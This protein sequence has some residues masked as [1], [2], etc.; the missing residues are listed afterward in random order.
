MSVE[1]WSYID[2]GKVRSSRG[3][4]EITASLRIRTTSVLDSLF[5]LKRDLPE[6]Q[7]WQPHPDEKAFFVD[8]FSAEQIPYSTR[9][10]A[11]VR[12]V[13]T[14]VRNPLDEPA[15]LVG[16]RTETMPGATIVDR[17]G[18]LILNTAGDVVT[19][20]DKP[21]RI[22]VFIFEK[23][24]PSLQEWLFDLEDVTNDGD[25]LIQ[26]KPR[27]KQTLLLRKVEISREQEIEDVKYWPCTIEVAYRKSLWLYKFPSMG[28]NQLVEAP[29]RTSASTANR[30]TIRVRQ[31][32]KI[33]GQAPT[34]PQVLDADGKW[35]EHPNPE[36]L[37]MLEAELY[38]TA[39][40]NDIPIR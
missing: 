24:L 4:Q 22:K 19:P 16:I 20:I 11:T 18:R 3:G 10:T 37:V 6:F 15:K 7:R 33:H 32:I 34:D 12:Y 5:V 1:Q 23:N 29:D 13:D 2:E 14:V 8:E 9:W 21:E 39:N 30:N 25:V 40:F 27:P 28:F 38:Q 35:I 17:Q 31:A 36:D 26:G